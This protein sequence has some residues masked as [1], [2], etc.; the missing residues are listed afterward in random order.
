MPVT[1]LQGSQ[2]PKSCDYPPRLE[3]EFAIANFIVEQST[4]DVD[5]ELVEEYFRGAHGVLREIPLG[6]LQPGSSENNTPSPAKERRYARMNPD[7]MPPLVVENGTIADGNHRYRVL[8]AR[9]AETAWCYEIVY[10]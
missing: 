4:S 6:E 8:V 7:T 1:T 9:G 5:E 3:D 2:M 10:E